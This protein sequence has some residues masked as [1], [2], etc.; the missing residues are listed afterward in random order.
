MLFTAFHFAARLASL[1]IMDYAEASSVAIDTVAVVVESIESGDEPLTGSPLG[2]AMLLI[3]WVAHES[4]GHA[5]A[6]NATG[7]DSGRMQIRKSWLK[8]TG[9]TEA[10]LKHPREGIRI[11][12]SIMKSLRPTCGSVRGVLRAYSSG[13]CAGSI[14]ARALVE[15][16]CKESGSC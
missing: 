15:S 3:D 8:V 16:R 10:D 4:A 6:V 14:R 5:N 1:G 12:Y 2:D 11:G 9:K 7:G 13:T